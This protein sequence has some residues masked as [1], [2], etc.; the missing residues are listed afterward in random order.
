VGGLHRGDRGGEGPPAGQVALVDT[1]VLSLLLKDR[2]GADRFRP[3]LP[4]RLAIAFVTAAEL[5]FGAAK[6]GWGAKRLVQL[7][8]ALTDLLIIHTDE[9]LTRTYARLRAEAVRLGHPLGHAPNANDLWIAACAVHYRLPLVTRNVRHFEGLP[10][11]EIVV[12]G[13]IDR[14]T[15]GPVGRA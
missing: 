13:S 7:E 1:D 6:A 10:G 8:A 12:A 5:R 4:T 9:D 3:L 15:A 11:L 14:W 2:P